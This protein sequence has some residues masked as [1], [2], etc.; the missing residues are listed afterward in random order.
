MDLKND[1]I[2]DSDLEEIKKAEA[3]L[4]NMLEDAAKK[5]GAPFMSLDKQ[6]PLKI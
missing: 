6:K 4:N 5:T 2:S 3:E 1:D